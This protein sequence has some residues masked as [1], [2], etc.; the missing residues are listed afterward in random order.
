[1]AA[2][3]LRVIVGVSGSVGSLH[4]LRC[5]VTEARLRDRAVWSVIAWAPNGGEFANTRSP[6]VSLLRRSRDAATARMLTA[7]DEAL[8]GVPADLTV[9][10][11]ASRGAPGAQLVRFADRRNDL[12]VVG[13]GTRTTLG[14]A[15]T[16]RSVSRYCLARARCAVLTVPGPTLEHEFA[17]HRLARRRTIRQI[18]RIHTH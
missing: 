3:G 16:G 9:R 5:A 11:V 10:M 13:V 6:S 1:M 14:R 12:L 7:W 2:D 18:T 8:G 17:H 4:A 15:V